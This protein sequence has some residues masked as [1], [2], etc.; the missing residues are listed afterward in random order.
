MSELQLQICG[1]KCAERSISDDQQ[2]GVQDPPDASNV[3]DNVVGT[4]EEWVDNATAVIGTGVTKIGEAGS[5]LAKKTGELAT[6]ITGNAGGSG[7]ISAGDT[8]FGKTASDIAGSI[9][10]G[11]VD[12]V[13]AAITFAGGL[14]GG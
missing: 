2:A 7:S 13:N 8:S 3:M 4:F 9:G 10:S 1:R 6:S 11:V 5:G 14:F 12:G